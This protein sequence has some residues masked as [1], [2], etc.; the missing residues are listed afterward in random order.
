ML[1]GIAAAAPLSWLGRGRPGVGL[2][3]ALALGCAVLLPRLFAR[4]GLSWSPSLELVW[5]APFFA[6]WGLGEG[7]ELFARVPL[8]DSFTHALGGAMA[9]SLGAAWARPRLRAGPAAVAL[10][11]VGAALAAGALWEIGEF[12]SDQLL[13]TFTQNGNS[14]TMSDLCFDL[15]GGAAAALWA[16]AL[17]RRR[18]ARA[19]GASLARRP[20][21]P[22]L[23]HGARGRV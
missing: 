15:A 11:G 4:G 10:L 21:I 1:A 2:A 17:G 5:L 14:D 18:L 22:G 12:A 19:A 23:L 7:F 13:A 6:A 9:F 3:C 20:S 16:L 8:W